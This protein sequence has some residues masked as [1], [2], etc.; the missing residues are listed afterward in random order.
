MYLHILTVVSPSERF[1]TLTKDTCDH[2]EEFCD[3]I[4]I[5]FIHNTTH[6]GKSFK[7]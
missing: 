3:L 7:S 6:M 5:P 2:V 1:L 4:V